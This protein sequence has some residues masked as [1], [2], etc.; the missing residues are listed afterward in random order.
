LSILLKVY[1]YMDFPLPMKIVN[2]LASDELKESIKYLSIRSGIEYLSTRAIISSSI[3]LSSIISFLCFLVL[4]FIFLINVFLS[5]LLSILFFIIIY[6]FIL[7]FP[8]R[9]YQHDKIILSR[10]AYLILRELS[11]VIS[12]TGSLLDALIF[13]KFGNYPIISKDMKSIILSC[14]NGFPPGH[15]LNMYASFLPSIT[16]R[17]GLKLISNPNILSS[18]TLSSI[19]YLTT[20]EIKGILKDHQS[21]IEL[22]CLMLIV[23]GLLF[24]F[25]YL[26]LIPFLKTHVIDLSIIPFIMIILHI[27]LLSLLTKKLMEKIRGVLN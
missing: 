10:Y 8:I 23:L 9:I 19:C 26:M 12:I 3:A 1:N 22:Y 14:F 2:K 16:L 25:S 17:N 6:N 24:P 7:T 5:F 13:I 11:M 21:K 18:E 20:S 4:T 27:I 15:A